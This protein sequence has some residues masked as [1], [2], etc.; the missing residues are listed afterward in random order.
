MWKIVFGS[1][2]MA[3]AVCVLMT[4]PSSAATIFQESFEGTG[5]YT[6]TGEGDDGNNFWSVLSTDASEPL[7]CED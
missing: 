5:Q 1:A 7:D 6:V 2:P 3:L 4:Q